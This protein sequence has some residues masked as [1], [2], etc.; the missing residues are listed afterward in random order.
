M[1]SNRVLCGHCGIQSA[2][3]WT[4]N[5]VTCHNPIRSKSGSVGTVFAT[6]C[7]VCG[8]EVLEYQSAIEGNE[9]VSVFPNQSELT[10][11]VVITLV[12]EIEN[13]KRQASNEPAMTEAEKRE[14]R[15]KPEVIERAK[16][17]ILATAAAASGGTAAN[18]IS[19]LLGA[20]G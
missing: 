8:R 3:P 10:L 16:Q 5:N 11:E 4:N 1:S 15:E 9:R 13:Y 12:I 2:A 19:G 18:I 6:T 17:L 14:A 20:G 7:A